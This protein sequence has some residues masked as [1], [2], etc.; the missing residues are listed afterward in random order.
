[1]SQPFVTHVAS[2][3]KALLSACR[4][5][6]EISHV[7][8]IF[9]ILVLLMQLRLPLKKPMLSPLKD[10]SIT[11]HYFLLT[12]ITLMFCISAKGA[13]H[14]CWHL[15]NSANLFDSFS[16]LVCICLV[17]Q[18]KCVHTSLFPWENEFF[19]SFCSMF[20]LLIL[21]R[22]LAKINW[23]FTFHSLRAVSWREVVE[24]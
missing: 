21:I 12:P 18:V 23:Q 14:R 17:C 3:V 11:T 9:T 13:S 4:F 22:S 1:M 20:G 10:S 2:L 15:L 6:Q 19:K 7:P 8:D 5:P 24:F 16:C